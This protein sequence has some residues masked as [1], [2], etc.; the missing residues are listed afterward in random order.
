V[1]LLLS[2]SQQD[3][4][5]LDHDKVVGILTRADLL[6]ALARQGRERPVA[7]VMRRDFP[8]ADASEMIEL[9]FQR[10]Q[11]CDCH[12]MPVLRRGNLVGLITMENV[13]EFIS[14]QAALG[15]AATARA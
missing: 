6:G 14:V 9:A 11:E 12:T 1:E 3:F 13:G 2:G 15:G 7:D 8:V 4:P 10:L 5:V